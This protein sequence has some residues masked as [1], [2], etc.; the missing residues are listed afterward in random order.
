MA[1]FEEKI[2]ETNNSEFRNVEQSKTKLYDLNDDCLRCIISLLDEVD[3]LNVVDTCSRFCGL[4]SDAYVKK[5]KTKTF[6]IDNDYILDSKKKQKQ[7]LCRF[8]DLIPDLKVSIYNGS[9]IGL[10][11]IFQNCCNDVHELYIYKA[12]ISKDF[13][14]NFPKLKIL[15]LNDVNFENCKTIERLFPLLAVVGIYG[16]DNLTTKTLNNFLRVNAQLEDLTIRSFDGKCNY[17]KGIEYM[18]LCRVTKLFLTYFYDKKSLYCLI[19]S[20]CE[21]IN[22]QELTIQLS[23]WNNGDDILRL[24][25]RTPNIRKILITNNNFTNMSKNTIV[26]MF[27]KSE[28]LTFFNVYKIHM[29]F[30]NINEFHEK[31]REVTSNRADFSI[32]LFSESKSKHVNIRKNSL[33]F[34]DSDGLE[35]YKFSEYCDCDSDSL[36][37]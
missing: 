3:L 10:W 14:W 20:E 37:H 7:L 36:A 15:D 32:R 29:S 2:L 21:F 1:N 5:F 25:S 6:R 16:C 18:C 4:G 33:L 8:G 11:K 23:R 30:K 12:I 31:L 24:T 27:R 19:N 34:E 9:T 28:F 13:E 22:L 35:C 17:L 26:E